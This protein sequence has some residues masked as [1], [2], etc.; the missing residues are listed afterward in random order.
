MK[1]KGV[2]RRN[3]RLFRDMFSLLLSK[4]EGSSKKLVT[5]T[6]SRL[7]GRVRE[8]SDCF[9]LGDPG[10]GDGEVLHLLACVPKIRS[11]SNVQST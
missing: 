8:L 3:E 4:D 2:S 10:L 5:T 6:L 9:L 1:D 11:L 7:E